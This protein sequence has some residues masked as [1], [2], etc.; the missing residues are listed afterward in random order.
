MEELFSRTR[1]ATRAT[2]LSRCGLALALVCGFSFSG[3]AARFTVALDR[4]S[5]VVG[6]TV[7]LTLSFE[8]VQPQEISALPAIDGLQTVSGV[9]S[10]INS[11]SGPGGSSTVWSYSVEL[12]PL[13]AGEFII[14]A[15]QA[16]VGGVK[17]TSQPLTLKVAASDASAPPPAFAGKPVFLWLLL[18][19]KEL[20]VGEVL[21]AE[22]RLYI[23]SDIRRYG[24][25]Q[26]PLSGEGFTASK[27]VEGQHFQRRLGTAQFTIIP[28]LVA[29][30]PVK[31]GAL[32]VGPINGSILLNP[33]DPFEF[34]GSS[35]QQL[36]LTLDA[37]ML[38]VLPLPA[39]NVPAGFNGAVGSYTLTFTAGPTNVAAGDPITVNVTLS[40]QGQLDALALPE[41]PAWRDF[42][43][44]PPTVKPVEARDPFGAQG[45]KSFEQVVIPQNSDIHELPPF[46]FSFFDPALKNYR[47]LTQPAIPLT[48]RPGGTTPAP[49]AAR[50]AENPPP[51]PDVVP[52]KQ[53]LGSVAVLSPP[54]A[55]QGWFLALQGVP[56]L[57]LISA[58]TWRKRGEA[59]ARNPRRGRQRRVA[60]LVRQGLEQ[61]RRF[62]A[63]NNSEEFFATLFRLLQEQLGE[64]LDLPASAITEAV[65]DEQLEPR[66][67]PPELLAELRDLFQTCNLA[68][69]AAIKTSGELAAIIP[70][71]E[72]ALNEIREAKL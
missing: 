16:K 35:P 6:E 64:R 19:K 24:N 45:T 46:S 31:S 52:I 49:A 39:E 25:L 43:I 28:F 18:P 66:G 12:A 20:Y 13:R 51:A 37:Q 15:F 56:A 68:R 17:V 63:A 5:I 30:T 42:K 33:P 41:Q 4:Y 23:R 58:V 69:Y 10:R 47:T 32:A 48:V 11:S 60:K 9:S 29:L 57:A 72:A 3:R 67:L 38:E 71:L 70:R 2:F 44:Y 8:G 50:T 59:L 62:A 54:L 61:L 65:I 22:L 40:G 1:T 55:R 7:T 27:F 53:R 21:V 36:P 14:P 34:F 26:L